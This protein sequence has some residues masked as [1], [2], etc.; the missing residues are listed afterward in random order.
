MCALPVSETKSCLIEHYNREEIDV[1]RMICNRIHETRTR[2]KGNWKKTSAG[3][4]SFVISI[5]FPTIV[6]SSRFAGFR[7]LYRIPMFRMFQ[8]TDRREPIGP[9]EE[10]Q[11]ALHFHELSFSTDTSE[12]FVSWKWKAH[13]FSSV[14]VANQSEG[15]SLKSKETRS[16]RVLS[17]GFKAELNS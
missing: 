14:N 6:P 15:N 10:N 8:F 3:T 11:W 16:K 1:N 13:W 17:F 4:L 2:P 7:E 5:Q 9:I 12:P